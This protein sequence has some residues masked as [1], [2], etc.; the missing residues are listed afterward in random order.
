MRRRSTD[1]TKLPGQNEVETVLSSY[2]TADLHDPDLFLSAP[3]STI[4]RAH[5]FQACRILVRGGCI[6][7]ESQ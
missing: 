5:T 3:G 7:H 1:S 2:N 4:H 6:T